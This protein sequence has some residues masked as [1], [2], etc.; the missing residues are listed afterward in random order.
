MSQER[1]P[2]LLDTDIGSDIDDALCLAYLLQQPRCEL[3]G[4]TTVTGEAEKRAMLADAL[5]RAAGREDIP[6]KVGAAQP[7]LISQGQPRAQQA[8]VLDAW[9]H[10]VYAPANEAIEFLRRTIRARPGEITLLSIGPLTNLGLLFVL[11]PEIPAL[12]KR[13]VMMVGVF[14]NGLA[15]V[16]PCEWNAVGDPHATAMVYRAAQGVP[17]LSVGLDVTCRCCLPAAEARA[18]LRGGI[19]DLVR[20]MA[21]VWF[22][23]REYIT[24]H[25]PLAGA[26]VFAPDLLRAEEGRVE[27]ELQSERLKGLTHWR[28]E[29]GGPHRVALGVDA[30][31]FFDHYFTVCQG[32]G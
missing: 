31:A 2:V 17:N 14:T 1:I 24:F 26:A 4:I 28:A 11:D 20:A 22:R 8:E 27:V 30:P 3:L 16:G 9:P 25:D 12:L 18:K 29:T 5:C 7:F 32:N 23:E 19:L 6:I 13:L 15:G 10:K 21:E